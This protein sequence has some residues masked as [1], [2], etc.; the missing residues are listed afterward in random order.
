M[1]GLAVARH[2]R[3]D[4]P[5]NEP[6]VL[7]DKPDRGRVIELDTQAH[8][9]GARIGQTVLQAR[10]AAGGVHVLV[11]DAARTRV[12]WQDMLDALDSV[13]PLVDD[14]VEGTAY[15]DM[16]GID[17]SPQQWIARVYRALL[18]FDLPVRAAIGPNKFVARAMTYASDGRIEPLPIEILQLD[19][20]T[21]ERLHLL[22]I[23]TLGELAKLPH[24]PFV[25]RFGK[26]AT[27]WHDCARGIDPT[28][29]RPRA[30]E[31][32]I[33]ASA[34]GEGSA[35][36]EEQVYFALRVLADRVCNDLA[37]AGKA[38][39]LVRVTFECDNGDVREL[40]TGFAQATGDPRTM[41]D[42]MRAKLEGL[43]FES[44][45]VGLRMQVM[46]LEECGAVATLFGQHDPDP[47]A[48]AVALARLQAATGEVP[49]RARVHPAACLEG[50]F[51]WDAF[52]SAGSAVVRHAHHDQGAHHDEKVVPQ[53]RLLN[54]K[55]IA[56]QIRG[57][58]P[59]HV[60][61]RK[62]VNC[63]GPWRVDDGWF[64]TPVVR[65]EYDVL[66]DDG[67]LCRI[68]RQGEHW[69]LRGAYD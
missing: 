62:V 50:R 5:E 39:T 8:D 52:A 47:Q 65:D 41:L 7:A 28:P 64:E 35:E 34:F 57:N 33:E 27:V 46:R 10:A 11:H 4:V 21:V 40:D 42:V 60:E 38:T 22:G 12:V 58:K 48:I 23:R 68:Y 63:A 36:Q 18:G 69:Y 37:R 3:S 20:R 44:P 14:T 24:G 66:L 15:L 53:L 54:V 6:A 13:T 31:L 61:T 43:T 67:M 32:Q 51:G 45:I 9:L 16:R 49:H 1:F 26:A 59:V 56:V 30:H 29:F 17:G 25:R 19:P 55:K 2:D